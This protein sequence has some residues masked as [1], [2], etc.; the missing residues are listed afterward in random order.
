[1]QVIPAPKKRLTAKWHR[2][3]RSGTRAS[4]FKTPPATYPLQRH[5]LDHQ[6]E[7]PPGDTETAAARIERRKRQ[8]PAVE[9]LVVQHKAATLI[10]QQL[11][12][13]TCRI[14]EYEHLLGVR[15]TAHADAYL[16]TQRIETLAQIRRPAAQV[17]YRGIIAQTEHNA[18]PDDSK[19]RRPRQGRR[20]PQPAYGCRYGVSHRWDTRSPTARPATR[21]TA[22]SAPKS[23][24]G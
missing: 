12:A 11:D 6:H 15:V 10:A 22:A 13:R 9:P 24:D 16:P 17:I 21:R 14:V 3:R 5:P 8:Y 7:L 1:M 19:T 18:S 23:Q 2:S 4:S 20:Q